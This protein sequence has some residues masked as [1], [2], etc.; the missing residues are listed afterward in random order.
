[1]VT[2]GTPFE[3]LLNMFSLV[4]MEMLRAARLAN[5]MLQN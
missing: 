5:R 4:T 3:I 1:M 2:L